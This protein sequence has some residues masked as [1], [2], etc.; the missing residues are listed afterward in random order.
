M[1]SFPLFR[2][3]ASLSRIALAALAF[4]LAA[5]V[6]FLTPRA[7]LATDVDGGMDCAKPSTMDFGDAPEGALAYPGIPGRF[8]TCLAA[9]PPGT[10]EATC[11]PISTVPG[12]TGFVRHVNPAGSP[13]YWL[14]CS[15]G[16]DFGIDSEPDGKMNATGAA[17]SACNAGVAVDCVEPAF[18]MMFGQDECY[19]GTDAGIDPPPLVFAACSTGVVTF[20]TMNCAPAPRTVYLNIL[21]DMNQDG[22]WNDN[23]LCGTVCAYEWAVKNAVVTLVPGCD[24]QDSPSFL[25]G[26][27]VCFSWLRISLSDTPVTDD[28]PWRGSAGL[29]GQ[30]LQGGETEDYPVAIREAGGDDCARYEDFGDAPE[31]IPAYTSGAI[32]RFPTCTAPTLPGTQS[33]VCAPI[34]SAPA[35]TGYVRHV[36]PAN[37]PIKIWLGCGAALP[38]S[39]DSETDGKMNGTGLG[40]SACDPAV[41]VDCAEPAFAGAMVFG[42]DECWGDIDA[43][44]IGPVA[45]KTCEAET[46]KVDA[47]NCRQFGV[48][49][50]LNVL[51]DWNEDGD[52]NDNLGCGTTCVYEWS[53]QNMPVF[54]VPGC[55]TFLPSVLAGPKAGF[56]WMRVTLTVAPV[57]PDYPW[58]GSAGMAGG[59]FLGGETEDYP[60]TIVDAATGVSSE[61]PSGF[62]LAPLTP[63][64][65]TAATLVRFQLPR[66]SEV[67]IV[68][69]DVS[70]RAVRTLVDARMPAG[71]QQASW[72]FRDDEGREL[73][74]G[75]YLVQMRAGAESVTR[76]VIRLN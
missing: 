66:A 16:A 19:G 72:D 42:Q 5:C 56:G 7:L 2:L 12:P 45:F 25:I 74:A 63:N 64:P 18:G 52:W 23:F 38:G 4:A 37:D 50:F 69:Y 71:Q 30:T 67:K 62:A 26:P 22:D 41:A 34:S 33:A 75:V 73:P 65:T 59:S 20:R 68:A 70:G 76:R 28:Y 43:G 47:F 11:I 29:A 51:V 17:A 8:P 35:T 44:V 40:A 57:P 36:S 49:A 13:H 60:V 6:L 3:S 46:I 39:V 15:P 58:A 24:M 21:L 9:A 54:L 53:V 32:G 31:G 27:N 61:S 14:N 55:N 10:Q 1:F 48:Q